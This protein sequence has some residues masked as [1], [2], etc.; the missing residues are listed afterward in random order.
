[1]NPFLEVA[2]GAT[3]GVTL[4]WL[5][6]RWL[7]RDARRARRHEE[8]LLRDAQATVARAGPILER[9]IARLE[10]EIARERTLH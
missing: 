1:M 6:S 5:T 10:A 8:Q 9:E 2:I 4:G 7:H 3:I